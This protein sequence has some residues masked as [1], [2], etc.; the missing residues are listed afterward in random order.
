MRVHMAFEYMANDCGRRAHIV[1]DIDDDLATNGPFAHECGTI[2]PFLGPRK[3]FFLSYTRYSL[4]PGPSSDLFIP[5]ALLLEECAVKRCIYR[6][7]LRSGAKCPSRSL[8]SALRGFC[9]SAK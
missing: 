8:V 2:E 5:C 6:A 1:D 3:R 7:I 9:S 4:C